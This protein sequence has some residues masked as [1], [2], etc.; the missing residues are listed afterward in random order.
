MLKQILLVVLLSI[1]AVFFSHQLYQV[2][3]LLVSLHLVLAHTVGNIFAGG[4]LG[5]FIREVVALLLPA[6]FVAAIIELLMRLLKQDSTRCAVYGLWTTWVV[7]LVLIG[8]R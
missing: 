7:L 5:Y 1:I 8:L 3:N 2:L 6:L 4:K